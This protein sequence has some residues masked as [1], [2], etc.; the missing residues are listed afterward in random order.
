MIPALTL[1]PAA[2]AAPTEVAVLVGTRDSFAEAAMLEGVRAGGRF[3]SGPW[4][5]ELSGF[6]AADGSRISEGEQVELEVAA[7]SD[8]TDELRQVTDI[9]AVAVA[10]L[11]SWGPRGQEGWWGGPRVIAG[12]ELR[13]IRRT[14]WASS[15]DDVVEESHE[16]LLVPGADLGLAFDARLGGPLGLRLSVLDRMWLGPERNFSGWTVAEETRLYQDP[17]VSLDLSWSFAAGGER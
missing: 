14:R 4:E 11:G 2:L 8:L 17:T 9:D 6:L 5:L 13:Q 16:M 3:A 1:I 15:G 12:V 7:G 10:L